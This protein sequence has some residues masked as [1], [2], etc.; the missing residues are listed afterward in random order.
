MWLELASIVVVAFAGCTSQSDA[1]AL[2]DLETRATS[3]G[4]IDNGCVASANPSG[5]ADCMNHALEVNEVATTVWTD[6][7]GR[8]T[9]HVFVDNN[10]VRAF[11][12]Q[13]ADSGVV[14][15]LWS[16]PGPGSIE[17]S[18]DTVCGGTITPLT[19]PGCF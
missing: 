16:C 3:C 5:V 18:V 15:E 17:V 8:G 10:E 1:Q 9:L 11:D 7:S 6:A 2:T 12:D 13:R 14:T 19:V 4:N